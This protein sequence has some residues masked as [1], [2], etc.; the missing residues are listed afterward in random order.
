MIA[1][2]RKS[3]RGNTQIEKANTDELKISPDIFRTLRHGKVSDSY[4]LISLLGEGAYG[5]VYRVEQKKTNYNRAMKGTGSSTR[6]NPTVMKKNHTKKS[7]E[8]TLISE[9]EIMRGLDHPGVVSLYELY[10]DQVYFYLISEYL[11]GGELFERIKKNKYFSEKEAA[12]IMS[13]I[14]SAV[15]YLHKKGIVHRDLKPENILFVDKTPQSDL[16]VIDFGV[17]RNFSKET[18]FLDKQG[19]VS[20]L[21]SSSLTLESYYIAPEV[22]QKNSNHKSDI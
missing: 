17:S 2:D 22:L 16:K 8:S 7:E 4:K 10:Q 9:F 6:A 3:H 11:E 1:K 5:K 15:N 18:Q 13:Q 20:V 12:K 14:I 19:T 21:N